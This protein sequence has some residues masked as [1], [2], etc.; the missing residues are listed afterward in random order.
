MNPI[1]QFPNLDWSE[2]AQEE[3][4]IT[5]ARE[6]M[7]VTDFAWK[8]GNIAAIGLVYSSFAAPPWMWM[9]FAKGVTN[10][11][12]YDF[13]RKATL[14]P[15]GTLTAVKASFEMGLRFARLYG[16]EEAGDTVVKGLDYKIMRKK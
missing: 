4:L 10:R 8:I 11:D 1:D 16:F 15:K 6:L 7:M 14:I 9:I 3:L 5:D 2:H 12:L 13:R